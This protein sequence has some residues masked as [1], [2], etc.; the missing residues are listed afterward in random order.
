[1]QI[2]AYATKTDAAAR[3]LAIVTR[4]GGSD[5]DGS[6]VALALGTNAYVQQ[7]RETDPATAA[8]WAIAAV[9]AAEFGAK[10]R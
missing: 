4:S 7:L 1:V 6:D 2:S 10:V 5:F 9:N 3:N 8:A